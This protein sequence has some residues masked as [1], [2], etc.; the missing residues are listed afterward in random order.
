MLKVFFTFK[1]LTG[2]SYT[3]MKI[4]AGAR[5]RGPWSHRK[6]WKWGNI[7]RPI[8]CFKAVAVDVL[9]FP[10]TPSFACF[11]FPDN[12]GTTEPDDAPQTKSVL[13]VVRCDR[14]KSS[15]VCKC[16]QTMQFV[17]KRLKKD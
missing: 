8:V 1:T 9:P 16:G 7:W 13:Q 15:W 6:L 5:L 3:V 14:A 12:F 2:V 10:P 17:L 4:P 11:F